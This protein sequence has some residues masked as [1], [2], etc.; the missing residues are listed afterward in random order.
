MDQIVY[1]NAIFLL[2]GLPIGSAL[3]TLISIF[4]PKSKLPILRNQFQSSVIKI[5]LA[6]LAIRASFFIVIFQ[7]S[8]AE[9]IKILSQ[10]AT[11]LPAILYAILSFKVAQRLVGMGYNRFLALICVIPL[12]GPMIIAV[13]YLTIHEKAIK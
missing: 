12:A 4:L 7:I 3:F 2:I 9:T 11:V 5:V 8:D 10:S 6:I 13:L 1:S